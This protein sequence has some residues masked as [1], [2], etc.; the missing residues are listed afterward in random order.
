MSITLLCLVKGNTTASA[1]PIDINKDQLVGHLKKVIKAEKQND[2]AGIDADR[3]K[4]W[5]K[6]IPDDQDD[7]LSNLILNDEPE[8]L[9]TREIGDYW[10]EKPPKRNIHVLVSPPEATTASSREQ[11]LLDRIASLEEAL[12]KFEYVFDVIVSP[13]RTNG[14]KWNVDVRDAT[15]EGLK[16]YIRKEY[17]PPSLEKDGAVLNFICEDKK[18]HSPLNDQDFC[19]MLR[20]YVSKNN[21]KLIVVIETPSKA[22]SDWSF[23]KMCQLYGLSESEDPSLSVFPPFTYEYKDLESDSSR[24]ILKHLIAELNARLKAISISGNEASKSQY[25]CSYLVAG[26][27]L[28]EG[29][30]ELR[31][32]KNI[33]GP[34]GHGPVDFAIDLLQTAK[35]VGVTEVK[36]GTT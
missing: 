13:K 2:F 9:A 33:T 22:F 3:L 34:N 25:V 32:E 36:D 18:R 11:E 35:T 26:I 23:P 1:F 10:T 27:N 16:E 4:L 21:F 12:N 8:L 28:H 14:F 7:L 30:F 29:K 5:K 31:P 15:L 19:R 6:E 17:E 24:A 20:Q